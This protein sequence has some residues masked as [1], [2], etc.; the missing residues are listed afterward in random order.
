MISVLIGLGILSVAI[1][2]L[3]TI[4][5]GIAGQRRLRRGWLLD[6]IY[7]FFTALITK[8]MAQVGVIVTLAPLLWLTGSGSFKSPA[9]RRRGENPGQSF[10]SVSL[11][12]QI[13]PRF[14]FAERINCL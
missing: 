10:G 2:P 5:P 3:E 7:W 1:I 4:S 12:V 14:S 8:P 13:R 9:L 6:L 11:A